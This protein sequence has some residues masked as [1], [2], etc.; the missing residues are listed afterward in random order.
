M[1]KSKKQRWAICLG[2]LMEPVTWGKI[3]YRNKVVT[4]VEYGEDA[5]WWPGDCWQ[6]ENIKIV[7]S[8]KAARKAV[9]DHEKTIVYDPR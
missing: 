4:N 1:P 2:C 7:Y 5:P 8:E 6:S 9:E 3:T